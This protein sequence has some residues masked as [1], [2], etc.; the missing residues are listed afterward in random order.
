MLS[1]PYSLEEFRIPA[2]E[3]DLL[4]LLRNRNGW[5]GRGRRVFRRRKG[6][7]EEFPPGKAL[8]TPLPSPLSCCFFGKS[9]M[10][11]VREAHRNSA[12]TIAQNKAVLRSTAGNK[13]QR[14]R[15]G[16]RG[17]KKETKKPFCLLLDERS[18]RDSGSS[19]YSR[20]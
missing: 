6:V 12:S 13:G 10:G 5:Q 8:F 15:V 20:T 4:L 18:R 2:S 1:F 14:D 7:C 17:K 11:G 19:S 16:S 9:A 3:S